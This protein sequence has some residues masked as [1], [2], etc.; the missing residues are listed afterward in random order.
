MRC[1]STETLLDISSISDWIKAASS[2]GLLLKLQQAFD[3]FQNW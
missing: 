1:G 2:T 3:A